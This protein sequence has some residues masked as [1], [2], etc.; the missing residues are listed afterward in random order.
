MM[1]YE[2]KR[3]HENDGL[4]IKEDTRKWWLMNIK[5]YKKMMAY[6]Y[7]RIQE[8]DGLWI[9]EDTRKW[10]LMNI[11]GYKKMMAY[12]YKRIQEN[13][14]LWIKEKQDNGVMFCYLQTLIAYKNRENKEQYIFLLELTLFLFINYSNVVCLAT[15]F[16]SS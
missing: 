3:I 2:Y 11:K 10:W 14:G 4:W 1:A 7:K 9:K 6:E 5:G 15:S 12:E 16:S 8:N 13:D